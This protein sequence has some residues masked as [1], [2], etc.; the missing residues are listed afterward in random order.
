MQVRPSCPTFV[1][2]L[3]NGLLDEWAKLQTEILVKCLPR[4]SEAVIAAKEGPTLYECNVIKV[5]VGV[6]V[7][8]SIHH[9]ICVNK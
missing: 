7:R 1:P 8:C 2:D 3:T 9:I 4:R 6:M 5:L